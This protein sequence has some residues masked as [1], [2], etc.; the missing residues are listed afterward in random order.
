VL[1]RA[2][3]STRAAVIL[4]ILAVLSLAAFW[5]G[6]TPVLAGAALAMTAGAA[7]TSRGPRIATAAGGIATVVALAV[8]LASGHSL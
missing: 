6:V 3:G 2:Q 1:P 5:S 4:R 7:D 8:T